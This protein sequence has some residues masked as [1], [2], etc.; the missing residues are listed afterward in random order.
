MVLTMSGSPAKLLCFRPLRATGLS[1]AV[2]AGFL[3]GLP[4]G[5]A[6]GPPGDAP[7]GLT[8]GEGAHPATQ[9]PPVTSPPTDPPPP[10]PSPAAGSGAG[11]TASPQNGAGGAPTPLSG[12]EA[13]GRS[14][15]IRDIERRIGDIK[16]Q[17]FRAKA[18][19]SLLSE[20]HLRSSVGGVQA[21][22]TQQNQMGRLFQ[23]VR[24]VYEL[25]GREVFRRSEEGQKVIPTGELPIWDGS[26]RPGD[27]TL[28][29][30]LVYRGNGSGVF[31]YFDQ[32]TYTAMAAHRFSV[33]DGA[34]ARVR[35]TCREQGNVATTAVEN[36]PSIEFQVEDS[37]GKKSS[38]VPTAAPTG[39]SAPTS[40]P[41][42]SPTA[43]PPS[44]P[45]AAADKGADGPR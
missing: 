43:A 13:G 34:A 17:V 5:H 21:A 2:L 28:T 42:A 29:V 35:V 22:I 7:G 8:D 1:V 40:T 16:D 27:H 45:A 6:A 37:S 32:Y 25:D 33:S 20:R 14:D 4:A 23:L 36:R 11:P 12:G 44:S 41:A 19:L 9:L 39:S 10:A 38:T 3:M 24:I 30:T 15:G 18:R 26:M 31:S